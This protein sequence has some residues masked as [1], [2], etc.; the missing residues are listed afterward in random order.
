MGGHSSI[1]GE[2]SWMV[3]AP[4]L[5]DF[6]FGLEV[7]LVMGHGDPLPSSPKCDDGSW[8]AN[9]N[10]GVGFGGGV[11]EGGV[12]IEWSLKVFYYG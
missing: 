8:N 9:L 2:N 1:R 11:C 10:S 6:L 3:V 12:N 4:R 7:G 5:F